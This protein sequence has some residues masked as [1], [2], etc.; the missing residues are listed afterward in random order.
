MLGMRYTHVGDHSMVPVRLTGRTETL[1]K[2]TLNST[3]NYGRWCIHL[4]VRI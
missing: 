3:G 2:T 4:Y 1:T